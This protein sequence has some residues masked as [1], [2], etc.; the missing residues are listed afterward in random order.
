MSARGMYSVQ[1]TS[2]LPTAVL[3]TRVGHASQSTVSG[4]TQAHRAASHCHHARQPGVFD[5]RGAGC[6]SHL[7][8]ERPQVLREHEQ[9][10]VVSAVDV[11]DVQLQRQQHMAFATELPG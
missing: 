3:S 5:Y 8:I 1:R 11:P 2:M 7:G 10:V 9:R 4:A 6:Q